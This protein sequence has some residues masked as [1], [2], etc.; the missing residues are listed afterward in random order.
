M[1]NSVKRALK[2]TLLGFLDTGM[3]VDFSEKELKSLG[4]DFKEVNLTANKIRNIRKKQPS[5]N[6]FLRNCS[7]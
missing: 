2:E 1:R 6:Q 4:I 7:M 3:D 5:Y